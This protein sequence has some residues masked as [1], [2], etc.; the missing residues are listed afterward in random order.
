MG[1]LTRETRAPRL[2]GRPRNRVSHLSG[3]VVGE[4]A[5]R[6]EGLARRAGGHEDLHPVERPATK[7]GRDPIRDLRRLEHPARPDLPARLVAFSGAEH[8]DAPVEQGQHVRPRRRRL[9]HP[10][11]HRRCEHQRRRRREAQGG[12]E[13]VGE[14]VG[15]P[16]QHAGGGGRDEHE[17]RPP[18]ELDVSHPGLG[19]L[20]EQI[21]V[22][23]IGGEG[24]EGQRSHELARGGGHH[25]PHLEAPVV[26]SSNEVGR[27]VGRDAARDAQHD[28][29]VG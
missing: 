18:G 19:L 21:A 12:E 10:A 16:G 20:V 14:A 1:P 22:H 3:A 26:Q 13:V 5:H 8:R 27:L 17:I 4:A 9:P 11:V 6:I 15:E 23:R 25:D 28:P 7:P 2:P 24:L 29:A